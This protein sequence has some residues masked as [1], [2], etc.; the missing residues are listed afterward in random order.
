MDNKTII[1]KIKKNKTKFDNLLKLL[2]HIDNVDEK[3][4]IAQTA[5]SFT[6]FNGTGYFTSNKL[7]NF[8]CNYAKT[9]KSKDLYTKYDK[10]TVLHIMTEAYNTGGHTRV[11]ERWIQL[12]P[13]NEKHS[14]VILS[15]SCPAPFF[16]KKAVQ[17]K[18]GEVFIYDRDEDITSKALKL[19]KLASK[20]QY[21]ILHVHMDDPTAVIAFGTEEFTRPVLFFNHASHMFWIGKSIADIVIDFITAQDITTKRRGISTPSFLP[22]PDTKININT[23]SKEEAKKILGIPL[24]KKIILT[25]GSKNKYNPFN[26]KSLIPIIKQILD[27]SPD[28]LCYVIGPDM[29]SSMWEK[30]YKSSNNRIIATGNVDYDKEYFDYVNSA[31]LLLDSWP[32]GG[33][34]TIVDA[35]HC[36]IPVLSLKT[37]LNTCDFVYKSDCYCQ[38]TDEFIKKA[39]SILSNKEEAK[40][41]FNNINELFVSETSNENWLKKLNILYKKI[42]EKHTVRHFTDMTD[43]NEINEYNILIFN[44]LYKKHKKMKLLKLLYNLMSYYL[45]VLAKNKEK[46]LKYLKNLLKNYLY[47]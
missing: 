28:T 45:N 30:A 2:E 9:L 33:G 46:R 44:Y 12:A 40:K 26:G 14:V 10:N 31:D 24:N 22:I 42:P 36:K 20:F 47:I 23:K 43:Y 6:T 13:D 25:V 8:Y 19:R 11:V 29:K 18:H 3:L 7:E 41:Y 16:L 1:Q 15:P 34:T 5:L 32:V 39:V 21:I 35:L 38:N 4:T 27:K 17:N 37:Y